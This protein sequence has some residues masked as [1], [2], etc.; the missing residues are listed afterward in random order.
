MFINS[1]SAFVSQSC[2]GT[3]PTSRNVPLRAL[4]FLTNFQNTI[5]F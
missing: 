4:N 1:V 5:N 3:E 2:E